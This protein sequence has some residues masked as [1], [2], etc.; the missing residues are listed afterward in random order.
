MNISMFHSNHSTYVG[1]A[2]GTI[3][4]TMYDS[5]GVSKKEDSFIV[6]LSPI[7]KTE[8]DATASIATFPTH[9]PQL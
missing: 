6:S 3:A 9:N 5:G 2:K 7:K 8:E 4:P 1:G